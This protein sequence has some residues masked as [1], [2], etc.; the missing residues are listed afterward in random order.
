MLLKELPA[1]GRDCGGKTHAPKRFMGLLQAALLVDSLSRTL[2]LPG[3]LKS[4]IRCSEPIFL[5]LL[6]SAQVH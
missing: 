1:T 5:S 6:L 3:L 4:L 2:S